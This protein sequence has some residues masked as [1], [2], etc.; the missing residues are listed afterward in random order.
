MINEREREEKNNFIKLSFFFLNYKMLIYINIS[1]NVLRTDRT[2][3]LLI[4]PILNSPTLNLFI[5]IK[6]IVDF[7]YHKFNGGILN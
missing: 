3:K 2:M 6:S 7:N 1:V 5:F 4:T